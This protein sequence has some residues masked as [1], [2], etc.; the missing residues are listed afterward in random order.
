MTRRAR[1]GLGHEARIF[2]LALLG[3]L[4]AVT[5]LV[6]LLWLE[7]H[8]AKVRWT[9]S[10]LTVSA[11]LGLAF[12]LRERVLRALNVISALLAA[13]RE[14]DFSLRGHVVGRGDDALGTVMIE[15]NALADLLRE[16]RLG[17][18]EASALLRKVIEEIDVAVFAF[19][20]AGRLVLTNAAG[21][22]LLGRPADVFLG[23]SAA[24]LGLDACLEGDAPR[25]LNATF[26]GGTGPWELRRS[27]FRQRGRPHLLVV[28]ADLRRALREEERQAWQRLVRVLGHEINNS[29]APIRSLAANLK[30]G[31]ARAPRPPEL[32]DDLA[33][34]LAVI[35][36]RAEGLG[37]FLTAYARL[38]KL[39][40][41]RL[42]PVDLGAVLARVAALEER[43]PVLVEGEGG[44]A[45]TLEADLDQLEQLLINLVR[46]AADAT[47]EA[48]GARVTLRWTRAP[49]GLDVLVDDEGPGPPDSSNLFVPFF[50]T[51]A[52]GSGI[53][54]VLCRQIAEAHGGRLSLGARP[55]GPGC[56]A[57]LH[58]PR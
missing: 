53:G 21:A 22:R 47:L 3:G 51:K 55:G 2:L 41:P 52:A 10:S 56:R 48:G 44:P 19:D 46:N 39:P 36:R 57:R 15:V 28:L 8:S 9:F 58:L 43:L 4:P 25:T 29:L 31:L 50:T 5:T 45:P 54:L 7:P 17:A 11:W 18:I 12:L 16:E 27:R 1:A 26:P 24:D 14:E 32:D 6:L 34:G 42:G 30:D 37:R 38:A 40:P 49:G 35:A 33:R 13:L 23:L 20:E